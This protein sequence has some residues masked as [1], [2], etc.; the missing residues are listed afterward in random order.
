MD[1]PR[2]GA[3]P[4][5]DATLRGRR[6]D[7]DRIH[8][9]VR[10]PR[11]LFAAWEISSATARDAAHRMREAGAPLRYQLRIERR[12]R[13]GGAVAPARGIDLP[14]ALG[15]EGW[16]VELESAGG[17][18][19][20]LIGLDAPGGFAPLLTSR[21]V[22]VPPD[23]P[24]AEEGV[25]DLAPDAALALRGYFAGATAPPGSRAPGGISSGGPLALPGTERRDRS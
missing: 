8:L 14:D 2:P 15:G 3:A 23:G 21:W 9:L 19:R 11:S 5:T 12:E 6:Y 13:E 1:S 7:E 20:A 18:C 16:Y 25:W 4:E 22:S 24:C 10:D 17:S